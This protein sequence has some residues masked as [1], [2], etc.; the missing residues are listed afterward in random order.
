M[1][2][3]LALTHRLEREGKWPEALEFKNARIKAHRA[4]GLTRKDASDAA[5]AEMAERFPPIPPSPEPELAPAAA[6][7]SDT[8]IRVRE[9]PIPPE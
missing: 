4:A 1:V 7:I 6:S 3:K 9:T 2:D 8:E 5:W